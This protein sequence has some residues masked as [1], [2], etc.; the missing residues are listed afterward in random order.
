MNKSEIKTVGTIFFFN[1][2]RIAHKEF[3]LPDVTVNQ[4]YYHEVLD[5]L[6][7]RVMQV[8]MEIADDWILRAAL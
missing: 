1:F 7:K 8:Q 3:V 4:K 5:H 6:R 2:H